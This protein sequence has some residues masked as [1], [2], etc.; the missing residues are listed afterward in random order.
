M[1]V[2]YGKTGTFYLF[3]GGVGWK[4]LRGEVQPSLKFKPWDEILHLFA[5][6][7]DPVTDS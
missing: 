2:K 4:C 3:G 5:S 1:H 7:M 6:L